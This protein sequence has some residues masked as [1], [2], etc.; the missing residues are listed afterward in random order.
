MMWRVRLFCGH[1]VEKTAHYTHKTLQAAFV[2]HVPCPECGLDPATI[3]DGQAR[4]LLE[5]SARAQTGRSAGE[6]TRARKPTKA[7][8]EAK[9]RELDAEV[10]RL[11]KG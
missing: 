6:P 4:G 7:E 10:V 2:G 3:V 11:R 9:V 1:V 8:L 5:Q